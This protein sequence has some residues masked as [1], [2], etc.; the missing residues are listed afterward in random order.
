MKTISFSLC[1]TA[2]NPGTNRDC[3]MSAKSALRCKTPAKAQVNYRKPQRT[4]MNRAERRRNRKETKSLG[5]EL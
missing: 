4:E 5:S 1:D 2:A 3:I